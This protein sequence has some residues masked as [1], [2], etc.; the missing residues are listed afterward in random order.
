MGQ[1]HRLQ[2]DIEIGVAAPVK[3]QPCRLPLTRQESAEVVLGEMWEADLIEPSD[4]PW[5]APVV[6]VPKKGEWSHPQGVLPPALH[7]RF[8]GPGGWL[9]VVQLAGHQKLVLAS[10]ARPCSLAQDC[11]VHRP[12]AMAIKSN[13]VWAVQCTCHVRAADGEGIVWGPATVLPDVP[14]QSA[15]TQGN[16]LD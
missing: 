8:L 9:P 5:A 1:T 2:H 7:R 6:I 16:V 12:R 11:L 15:G 13:V 3:L 4:S 14:E 10:G